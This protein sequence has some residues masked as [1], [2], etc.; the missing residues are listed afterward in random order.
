MFRSLL[1]KY[2]HTVS[3]LCL[4]KPHMAMPVYT[5]HPEADL[6][7]DD[8]RLSNANAAPIPPAIQ[9]QLEIFRACPNSH[10]TA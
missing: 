1:P 9:N 6:V 10:K 5:L 4:Y 3:A 7:H 2:R 8:Q